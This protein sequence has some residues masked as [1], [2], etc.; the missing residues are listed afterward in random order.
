M[1][2]LST[3][4][5]W[6]LSTVQGSVSNAVSWSGPGTS[7]GKFISQTPITNNVLSNVFSDVTGDENIASVSTYQCIFVANLNSSLA[8]INPVVW[9]TNKTPGG[10]IVSIGKDVIGPVNINSMIPQAAQIP[11]IT[12]APPRTVTFSTPLAKNSGILLGSIGSHQC[13]ALWIKRAPV[14]GPAVLSDGV[15]LRVEGGTAP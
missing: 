14:N 7:L 1:P 12:I 9:I 15:S 11:Y 6:F 4:I 3:D 5:V 13:A 8:L 2:I 10:V